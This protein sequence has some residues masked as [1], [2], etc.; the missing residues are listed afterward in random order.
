MSWK[1]RQLPALVEATV[2]SIPT[3][4]SSNMIEHS[5]NKYSIVIPTYT[6]PAQP[7]RPAWMD[8]PVGRAIIPANGGRQYWSQ[9]RCLEYKMDL[10]AKGYCIGAEITTKYGI[11]GTIAEF[12]EI[13]V[14]GLDF[15][16]YNTPNMFMIK[17]ENVTH[18]SL[19]YNEEELFLNNN[20]TTEEITC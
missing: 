5:I 4:K 16:G 20:N 18:S 19:L 17:R 9:Q 11:K 8:N 2:V 12:R 10:I 15:A 13:P 1:S 3:K 14:L 7:I 6:P